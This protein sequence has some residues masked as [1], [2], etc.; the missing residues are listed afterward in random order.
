MRSL[1]YFCLFVVVYT[2]SVAQTVFPARLD[3]DGV[4]KLVIYSSLDE[5]VS[6]PLMSRFQENHPRVEIIYHD[7]QSLD[8]YERV[9]AETDANS[10]TADLVIS[11]AMDLQMKLA[12]DGYAQQLEN[13]NPHWP[14]WAKWRSTAFGLTFE[15][16]VVVYHKPSFESQKPPRN[17]AELRELLASTGDAFF[18]RTA[19]YDVERSGLGFLFLVRDREHDRNIWKLMNSFGESKVK[20]YSNSSSILERVADG[21]LAFGYNIL[22]SYAQTW[23]A[24][25]SNL[26]IMLL[27]D[28]TVV[29]SR[30][31]LVP[32][33]AKSPEL[34]KAMLRFLMSREG[35]TIMANEVKLPVLHPDVQAENTMESMRKKYGPRLRPITL[36]PGLIAYLDQVKRSRLIRR[37]NEALRGQ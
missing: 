30:I 27:E 12:N 25:N 2:P 6:R 10:G 24:K 22:G 26:G 32:E 31:A 8:I 5:A 7:L 11:S 21:R 4:R 34:G 16:S 20:L 19:T 36:G 15:P 29:M 1:V 13:P 9:I 18:G 35:Q 33:G 17:R 14:N 23:Q 28:F 3:D 37:W